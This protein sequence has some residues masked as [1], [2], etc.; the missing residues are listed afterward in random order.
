MVSEGFFSRCPSADGALAANVRI[1]IGN[2][3]TMRHFSS[4]F[5][6]LLPATAERTA[7][8]RRNKKNNRLTSSR[9]FIQWSWRELNPRPNGEAMCFLHAYLSFGFR[10]TARPEPP[11]AAL[12][13]EFLT[14]GAGPPRAISDFA[15]PPCRRASERELPGDVSFQHLVP[16]LSFDLLYFNQAARA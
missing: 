14:F 13:P 15:A 11:T 12:S 6:W 1:I 7:A 4:F 2:S 3:T 16:K 9:L 5:S 10:A 8:R